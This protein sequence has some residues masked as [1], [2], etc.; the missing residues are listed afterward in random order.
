[1]YENFLEIAAKSI[2]EKHS[3]HEKLMEKL[4]PLKENKNFNLVK[5]IEK[6]KT[7]IK[8]FNNV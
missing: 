3:F 2:G 1:M 8:E 4:I 7:K 5:K 6:V